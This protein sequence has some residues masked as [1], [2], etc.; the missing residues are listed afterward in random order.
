MPLTQA[1]LEE[2]RGTPPSLAGNR[3]SKA[4][5]LAG[6]R[7]GEVAEAIGFSQPY[8]SDVIRG[9]YPEITLGNARRLAEF[10]GCA[11]EDLFPGRVQET[12]SPGE[13]RRSGDERRDG[14]RRT[15]DDR[16]E[17]A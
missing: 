8:I 9:R 5:D 11:I 4:V 13:D 6:L 1:Q 15:G 17:I 2:L 7:Q 16:R 12:A 10:F 3:I 14:D